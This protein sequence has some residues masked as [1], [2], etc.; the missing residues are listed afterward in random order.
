MHDVDKMEMLLQAV[1]YER[2]FGGKV[3]LEEFM[4]AVRKIVLPEVKSWC[5][6]LLRGREAFWRDK[7]G[8]RK[9]GEGLK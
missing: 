7:D 1:E 2:E 6:E 3:N 8:E 5:G 9:G 4:G